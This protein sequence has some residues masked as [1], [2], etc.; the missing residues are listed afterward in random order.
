[1]ANKEN[2]EN[3][4][5][6]QI[7]QKDLADDLSKIL[8]DLLEKLKSRSLQIGFD[9]LLANNNADDIK[10]WR[11]QQIND[12]GAFKTQLDKLV[13]TEKKT[14]QKSLENGLSLTE[15]NNKQVKSIQ[16]EVNKGIL[17]LR[18]SVISTQASN[19]EQVSSQTK[20]LKSNV[21]NALKESIASVITKTNDYG[22]VTYKNGRKMK[23]ENYMEMK[24]RTDIQNDIADNMVKAGSE[25]GIIFYLATYH[26]DCAPD[27]ADFQGKIYCAKDWKSI[28][29]KV[30]FDNVSNYISTH[31][32]MSV[33]DVMGPKGNYLTKRPNCRHYFQ[34]ISIQEVLDVKND[35][36]LDK[37]REHYNLNSS[38]KYKPEKY[39]ALKK[40]RYNERQIRK[41]K[42]KIETQEK[43]ASSFNDK[44]SYEEI[45]KKNSN[46]KILNLKLK[47]A[48]KI[49]RELI[50][51]KKGVLVRN[52][53]RE[54]YQKMVSDFRIEKPI[55]L[56]DR[57]TYDNMDIDEFYRAKSRERT[58]IKPISNESFKRLMIRAEKLGTT[59]VRGGK[60]VEEHLDKADAAASS[61][62]SIL[63]F[64]KQVTKSEVLE[65]IYHVE[66][67]LRK[68]NDDKNNDVRSILNEI[69]AKEY[70][71][72]VAKKYKI[73]RSETEETKK[74]LEFYKRK[75]A[76]IEDK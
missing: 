45:L 50:N 63:L 34:Y 16:K 31:N 4:K 62:G 40:Q 74:Q 48:Q 18:E 15:L 2:K 67:N 72:R 37:L 25:N 54:A 39:D 57:S 9:H 71:L 75:L 66:Q 36:D 14:L 56:K 8:G 6:N 61:I 35:G 11:Y 17:K 22:I 69:D 24:V 13:N 42:G 44:T 55:S 3:K 27:H 20:T 47:D 32:I 21:T 76:E 59:Y 64:R 7:D 51:S 1:M 26:G 60:W 38:G 28:C 19:I 33:E 53:N 58:N 41:I 5:K 46:L 65:E 29:P 10:K 30:Y 70:L 68:L 52:Y 49:Q 12:F 23:W 73:P 43:L